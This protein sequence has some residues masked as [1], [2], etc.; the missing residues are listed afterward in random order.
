MFEEFAIWMQAPGQW[1]DAMVLCGV[2][3]IVCIV[4]SFVF[5]KE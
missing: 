2:I 5:N 4:A 1:N 3:A